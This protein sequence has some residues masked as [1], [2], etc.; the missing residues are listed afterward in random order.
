ME[1]PL[2]GLKEVTFVSAYLARA[3]HV[4]TRQ[5][6]QWSLPR[7]KFFNLDVSCFSFLRFYFLKQL[8]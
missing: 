6:D 4:I 1:T 2:Q 7:S 3:S 5:I 8:S